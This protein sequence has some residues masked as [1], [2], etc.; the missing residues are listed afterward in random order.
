MRTILI[1]LTAATAYAWRVPNTRRPLALATVLLLAGCGSSGGA[2][3]SPPAP[4]VT[5]TITVAGTTR[6]TAV[7]SCSGDSHAFTA[8][9]G[10]ISVRLIATSDPNNALSV[11]VCSG[12]SDTSSNCAV[13][14]QRITVGETL[15]GVRVGTSAQT[16]KFLPFAC[17]FTSTLNTTPITYTAALTYQQ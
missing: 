1:A 10:Q 2:A 9:S 16:L 5:V 13:T 12:A 4:T 8:A 15:G 11:Q 3:T 17:V 7:N 6:Q 14:Q